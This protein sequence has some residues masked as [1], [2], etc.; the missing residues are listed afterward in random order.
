MIAIVNAFAGARMRPLC[1]GGR[2]IG[3]F[4]ALAIFAQVS[5][6]ETVRLNVSLPDFVVSGSTQK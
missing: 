6:S 2:S 1:G 4:C 5:F 3:Y